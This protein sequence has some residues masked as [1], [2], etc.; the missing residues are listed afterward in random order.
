MKLT[1]RLICE[2][3]C[4]LWD[5]RH[6]LGLIRLAE[7]LDLIASFCENV[8]YQEDHKWW[9]AFKEH[10]RA[11]ARRI[12]PEGLPPALIV[13]ADG[14]RRNYGTP[15]PT[16]IGDRLHPSPTELLFEFYPEPYPR[17][18]PELLSEAA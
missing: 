11:F 9:H 18:Q 5:H 16:Y 6:R 10:C 17:K 15:E 1:T 7:R 13:Y 4:D 12:M 2:Q 3:E 8:G 14:T